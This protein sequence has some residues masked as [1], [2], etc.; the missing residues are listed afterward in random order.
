[1]P[2]V[3]SVTEKLFPLRRSGDTAGV[4]APAGTE[5][6]A[7][8]WGAMPSWSKKVMVVPDVTVSDAGEKLLPEPAPCGMV[9]VAVPPVPLVLLVL[10]EEDVDA[11]VLLVVLLLL[12]VVLVVVAVPVTVSVPCIHPGWN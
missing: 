7:T 12:L 2:G 5:V 3:V 6:K 11:V 10:D 1:V 8:L 9:T 4:V